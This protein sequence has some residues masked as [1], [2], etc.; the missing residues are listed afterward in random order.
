MNNPYGKQTGRWWM[1]MGVLSLTLSAWAQP[2]QPPLLQWQRA[3]DGGDVTATSTIQAVNAAKGDYAVLAGKNLVRL[4]A[5]GNIVWNK[6]LPGTYQDSVSGYVPVRQPVAAAAT[7][8]DGVAVLALDVLNLY[9]VTKLDAAGAVA[10]TRIIDRATGSGAQL[11]DNALVS[12]PDGSLL[13][14]G[15]YTDKLSYLTITKLNR[16]GAVSGQWRINYSGPSPATSPVIRKVLPLSDGGYLLVGKA[17]GGAGSGSTGLAIKV[18][19]QYN[20]VW[21][22]TYPALDS[23][24]DVVSNSSA[25]GVYTAI[26]SGA[27]GNARL[28]TISPDG[29]GDGN[30]V[31]IFSGS[32]AAVSL[33]T[34]GAGNL[35]V[36][37]GTS[38]PNRDFRLNSVSP[39]A[40]IR[41]TKTFG[42]S[43]NDVPTGLLATKDGGYL[44]V[45]TTT[46]TD[47]DVV[48]RSTNAVAAWV[49][50]VG[51]SPA[52][53]TLS[54]QAPAYNCST[55]AIVF[56][57]TGGDG[58]LIT[59]NAPG[60]TRANLTDNFGIVEPQ[61]RNDPKM[62]LIQA[63]Q[64]G[65][66]VRY[67][68]DFGT[69]CQ[70]AQ[71]SS[72][73]SAPALTLTPPTYNCQTGAITFHT[74]GGDGTPVEFASPGVTGWTTNPSQFVDSELRTAYDAQPLTLMA[75]QNGQVATYVLDLKAVCGRA[76][77]AATEPAP[78]L[79]VAVLGNPVREVVTVEIKGAQDELLL[80]RLMDGR[81][82]IV[83]QRTVAQAGVTEQQTFDIRQQT[84]G[85]L[86]V[87]I[88]MNGQTKTFKVIKQ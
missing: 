70:N 50:K 59:Y 46:S 25:E 35:T 64:S 53:T 39:Q 74:N 54:L 57:T 56:N 37:D 48:G 12:A 29:K 44:L 11:T 85:V 6:R 40:V 83:E 52:V 87:Q 82:R 88:T 73:S 86:I 45:G 78:P 68:F 16:E 79:T 84:P 15:A 76:R 7:P 30:P 47:G 2:A 62:L 26:G 65:Q 80:L 55:G 28:L 27:G 66:T 81:G 10:W 33:T 32:N 43:G 71:P 38:A 61:L 41:W 67:A 9:Y 60:I 77:L 51:P 3:I 23:L 1:L 13:V 49:V 5:T 20:L 75:R 14:V 4:S 31:A 72:T 34:D 22:R 63:T 24:S 21:Q 19:K 69:Y 58:S 18:D 42:G 17:A 36:L 8:D